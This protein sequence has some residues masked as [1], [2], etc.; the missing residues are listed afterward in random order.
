MLTHLL[1]VTTIFG[2]GLYHSQHYSILD[3]LPSNTVRAIHK[4]T[5]GYLWIGTDEGLCRFNGRDFKVYTQKDGLG[6]NSIWDIIEDPKTNKLWISSYNFT[7][8]KAESG[9]QEYR[10][11][12]YI[13][14]F[15]GK[16]FKYKELGKYAL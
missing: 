9:R 14:E 4:D 2:Q 11:G 1:I 6:G 12:G 7:E 16:V 3:G 13:Q 5:R 8:N 10:Q 15:D